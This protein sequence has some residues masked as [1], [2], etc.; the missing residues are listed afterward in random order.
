MPGNS[1]GAG[2]A[3]A[4][5]LRASASGFSL[6]RA[7][8]APATLLVRREMTAMPIDDSVQA[9]GAG[10]SKWR[11]RSRRWARRANRCRRRLEAVAL[12]SGGCT[13]ALI[14]LSACSPA[15]VAGSAGSLAGLARSASSPPPPRLA[16]DAAAP[17]A[18]KGTSCPRRAAGFAAMREPL[19][20]AAATA[21]PPS[22]ACRRRRCS[23]A[24]ALLA[25]GPLLLLLWQVQPRVILPTLRR[26]R[27]EW[28]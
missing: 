20:T 12:C 24:V 27:P 14:T 22:A 10:C 1:L 6:R 28:R 23:L 2:T 4:S 13:V 19:S 15:V 25:A 9:G 5:A 16:E 3:A 21:P 18:R 8:H 26:F 11:R 17:S 7:P